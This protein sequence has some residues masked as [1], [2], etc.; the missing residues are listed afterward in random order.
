LA[1]LDRFGH[2]IIFA[3][4]PKKG[5]PSKILARAR[6]ARI[7]IEDLTGEQP[8]YLNVTKYKINPRYTADPMSSAIELICAVISD[9]PM[10]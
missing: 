4:P 6:F 8:S 3:V 10:R 7:A 1:V 2:E 9:A 5:L